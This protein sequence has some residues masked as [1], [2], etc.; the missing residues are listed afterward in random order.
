MTHAPPSSTRHPW[1]R[2]ARIHPQKNNQSRWQFENLAFFSFFTLL[3]NS[4]VNPGAPYQGAPV[5]ASCRFSLYLLPLPP[6]L[7]PKSAP[8]QVY[9]NAQRCNLLAFG[10]AVRDRVPLVKIQAQTLV[11]VVGR[12]LCTSDIIRRLPARMRDARR[13]GSLQLRRDPLDDPVMPMGLRRPS[14]PGYITGTSVRCCPFWYL[15]VSSFG[16]GRA[17]TYAPGTPLGSRPFQHLQVYSLG[18]AFACTC[19]PIIPLGS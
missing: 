3:A 14:A 13:V 16:S 2:S 12:W 17:Y 11:N 8:Q 10:V 7:Q 18:S 19:I 9:K 15:Q 1:I 4:R 5:N 6:P